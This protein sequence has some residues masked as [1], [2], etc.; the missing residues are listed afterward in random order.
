MREI[1]KV[2][3]KGSLPEVLYFA[4]WAHLKNPKIQ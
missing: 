2:Y 4:H 3:S 1:V